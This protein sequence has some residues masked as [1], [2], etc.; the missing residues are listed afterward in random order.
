MS[1]H[2]TSNQK[3]L[4]GCLILAF[5]T[6][7]VF[8][9]VLS[10]QFLNLDDHL[11]VTKNKHVRDGL[12][13]ES[14]QWAFTTIHAEFYHPVTWISLMADSSLY[15]VTARGYLTT[16]LMLHVL[17]AMLLFYVLF[18]TTG[19]LI[20]SLIVAALFALHPL[21]VEN[22][23]WISDRKDLLCTFFWYVSI[24]AYISH[25]EQPHIGKYAVLL[26]A[27]ICGLLS[28]P[29]VITL[30]C[31]LLL[32]DIWP[33]RRLSLKENGRTA[34]DD[35]VSL[36]KEKIPLLI[37]A[38][39]GGLT[40]IYA[41]KFGGGLG[42]ITDYSMAGRFINALV[43]YKG[44]VLKTIWP[45]DLSVFYP[46]ITDHSFYSILLALLL[47]TV[48]TAIALWQFQGR[49]YWFVGWFWFLGTIVPTIGI[50]K[51][52]DFAMADRY[53]YIPVTG[54]LIIIIWTGAE[55][56]AHRRYGRYAAAGL[57]TVLIVVLV[58]LTSRQITY[59]RNSKDLYRH[60]LEVT[61]NNYMAHF[62]LGQT[63][64]SKSRFHEAARHFEKAAHLKPDNAA[65]IV[66]IGHALTADGHLDEA[67]QVLQTCVDKKPDSRKARFT[68]GLV[69]VLDEQYELALNHFNT[70][71]QQIQSSNASSAGEPGRKV[72]EG[73]DRAV[74]M[75]H[76]GQIKEAARLYQTVL[77]MQP[78]FL[79]ARDRL[80]RL[81]LKKNN[82][83][84]ALA[85]Y[86][87]RN[88]RKW[89][90]EI[91]NSGFKGWERDWQE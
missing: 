29:M 15:G 72:K 1:E 22:V 66:K 71:A 25:L 38:A 68:L 35:L 60:A 88:D 52:G 63:L 65:L 70:L 11:Y 77:N 73:Y 80:S 75:E 41:Q 81:Y 69:L 16:N 8:Y 13:L 49:P 14:L 42:S 91:I 43:A 79:P 33:L 6:V 76:D 57:F 5:A 82:V 55:L 7:V 90:L 83:Q 40:A 19:F 2:L 64:A 78:D 45:L 56:L 24:W 61:E 85:I 21:N 17:N 18:R 36:I 44:Y 67:V 62:G 58:A 51:V 84:E 26:T 34:L 39:G 4:W 23:A 89:V 74:A 10:H 3:F 54:L 30:P 32:L 87:L 28:K 47:L 86:Q 48:A 27:F 50:I 20:R 31:V 12:N 37:L 53:T 59:W 46:Y 9:P